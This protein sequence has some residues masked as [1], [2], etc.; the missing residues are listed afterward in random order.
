[1]VNGNTWSEN[2]NNNNNNTNNNNNN[3]KLSL[4][5]R[6]YDLQSHVTIQNSKSLK[7]RR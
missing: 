5:V 6:S 4:H 1:M 2:N 7:G 3:K